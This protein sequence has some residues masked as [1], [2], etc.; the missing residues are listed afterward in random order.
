MTTLEERLD[1]TDKSLAATQKLL[2]DLIENTKRQQEVAKRE[3][4]EYKARYEKEQA[5]YL[6]R[7][8]KEQ[9]ENKRQQAELNKQLGRL[10]DKLGRMVEDFVV[11]DLPRQLRLLAGLDDDEPIVS[12]PHDRRLNPNRNGGRQMI[13][14]DA[15]VQSRTHVLFNET[16]STLRPEHVNHFLEVMRD[17]RTYFPEHQGK[18]ILAAMSSFSVAPEVVTHASRQ[19]IIVFAIGEGIMIQQNDPDFQWKAF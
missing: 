3:R 7:Y 4:E 11:P 15:V 10:T 16:K 14:I 8:E 1:N 2:H 6:A 19:G 13:E 17:I 9:A 12:T 5:E 18:T